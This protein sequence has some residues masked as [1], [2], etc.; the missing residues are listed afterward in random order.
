MFLRTFISI[1]HDMCTV[2][3][4]VSLLCWRIITNQNFHLYYIL[5]G[6]YIFVHVACA[7]VWVLISCLRDDVYI[8]ECVLFYALDDVLIYPCSCSHNHSST[9]NGDG[10]V[11]VLHVWWGNGLCCW[12]SSLAA[13]YMGATEWSQKHYDIPVCQCVS[14]RMCM[15]MSVWGCKCVCLYVYV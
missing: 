3:F 15:H 14:V 2:I 1:N 11:V 8:Y 6:V 5:F 12:R 10:L 4:Y 9:I 7:F 13:V